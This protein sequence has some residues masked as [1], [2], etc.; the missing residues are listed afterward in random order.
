MV[1]IEKNGMVSVG[2]GRVGVINTNLTVK[3]MISG[4]SSTT[5][6]SIAMAGTTAI[7]G[8]N[9]LL[10]HINLFY[11]VAE[12]P[13]D[14][15]PPSGMVGGHSND[16]PITK[17][18]TFDPGETNKTIEAIKLVDDYWTEPIKG[19]RAELHEIDGETIKIVGYDETLISV[20]DNDG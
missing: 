10:F 8:A 18:V 19:I 4:C 12:L 15:E 17:L 20:L 7:L 16:L 14:F 9:L 11:Y 2:L 13:Q 1:Y 6:S 5:E 3:I